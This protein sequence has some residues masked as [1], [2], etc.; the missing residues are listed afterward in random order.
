VDRAF[1]NKLS[2]LIEGTPV[3]NEYKEA[4]DLWR[5]SI[6]EYYDGINNKIPSVIE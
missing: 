1:T 6:D 4:Y 2:T 3:Y 5:K